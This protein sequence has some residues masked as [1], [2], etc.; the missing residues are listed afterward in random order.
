M[1]TANQS[2]EN[3]RKPYNSPC[4]II[5]GTIHKLTAKSP[6]ATKTNDNTQ[7]QDSNKTGL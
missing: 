2:K 6:K 3:D 4:L 5:Y 1:T 7:G